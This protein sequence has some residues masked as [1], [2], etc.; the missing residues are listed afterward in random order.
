[1][2]DYRTY[3]SFSSDSVCTV[4]VRNNLT[5]YERMLS[6]VRY[7]NNLFELSN[8]PPNYFGKNGVHPQRLE[9]RKHANDLVSFHPLKKQCTL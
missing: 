7:A 8:N 1:M 9:Q 2:Q 5:S 6:T 4:P 3:E